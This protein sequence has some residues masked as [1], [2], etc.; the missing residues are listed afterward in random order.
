MRHIDWHICLNPTSSAFSLS[1]HK[2]KQFPAHP[3][4]RFSQC[5]IIVNSR[6]TL[7]MTQPRDSDILISYT[8]S[9]KC[10]AVMT[11]RSALLM[12]HMKLTYSPK[13][14]FHCWSHSS[15]W[16]WGSD[17]VWKWLGMISSPLKQHICTSNFSHLITLNPTLG[18][19]EQS[20]L[21]SKSHTLKSHKFKPKPLYWATQ[22]NLNSQTLDLF[23]RSFWV[24]R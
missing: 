17:I 10:T 4:L 16:W 11:A 24:L 7:W 23:P 21:P 18:L 3:Y 20:A 14:V 12:N 19:Q 6:F 9:A 1:F 8:N 22:G 13:L 5:N 15:P 2:V